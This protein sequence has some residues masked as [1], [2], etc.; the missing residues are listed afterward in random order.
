MDYRALIARWLHRQ[1]MR[2]NKDREPWA[3]AL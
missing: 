3:Q 1:N 2:A